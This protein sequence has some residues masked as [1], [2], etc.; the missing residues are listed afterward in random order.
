VYRSQLPSSRLVRTTAPA[1]H[2]PLCRRRVAPCSPAEPSSMPHPVYARPSTSTS[3]HAWDV[4]AVKM[5]NP[6]PNRSR[7]QAYRCPAATSCLCA[8]HHARQWSAARSIC[9]LLAEHRTTSQTSRSSPEIFVTFGVRV[10]CEMRRRKPFEKPVLHELA[11]PLNRSAQFQREATTT[12]AK[13]AGLNRHLCDRYAPL[14]CGG[15]GCHHQSRA[16]FLQI[17]DETRLSRR[18]MPPIL[19]PSYTLRRGDS[20]ARHYRPSQNHA[21]E[22]LGVYWYSGCGS[23]ICTQRPAHAAFV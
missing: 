1:S 8:S 9:S 19:P 20:A 2:W 16:K 12:L 11:P 23:S 14:R 7:V 13:G 17:L 18:P 4:V 15:D 3:R 22:T 10:G 6:V 5:R 21:T